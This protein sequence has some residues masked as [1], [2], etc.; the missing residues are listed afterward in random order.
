MSDSEDFSIQRKKMVDIQLAARGI[1]DKRVLEAFGRCRESFSSGRKTMLART[2]IIRL[3]SV[4][5][6][7]SRNLIWLR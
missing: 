2:V 7:R 1:S 5:A 3:V 4:P 6:R